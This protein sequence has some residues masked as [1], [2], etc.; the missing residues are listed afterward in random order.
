[1][2]PRNVITVGMGRSFRGLGSVSLA[3]S[4]ETQHLPKSESVHEMGKV[5]V[6]KDDKKCGHEPTNLGGGTI[7][8][9]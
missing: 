3:V 1:M 8:S 4:R 2:L 5:H 7:R 9:Q 6:V